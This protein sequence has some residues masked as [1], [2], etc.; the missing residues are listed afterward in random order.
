MDDPPVP[1]PSPG[2][3]ER[4]LHGRTVR[5]AHSLF[6]RCERSATD[7]GFP[8]YP[9]LPVLSCRGFEPR[10]REPEAAR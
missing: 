9:N 8:R 5:G 6:W 7:P 10:V 2:L 4:C 1:S 3:C